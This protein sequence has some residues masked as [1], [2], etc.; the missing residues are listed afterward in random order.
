VDGAFGAWVKLSDTHCG[1]ADGLERAD[2][3]A[4]DLHKWMNMPYA[5]GC[6]L[7]KDKVSH[8]STFVYGHD[9]EYLKSGM[10][11]LGDAITNPLNLSLALSRAAYSFKAYMLFRAYGRKKFGQMVQKNIDHINYLAELIRKEPDLE[12]MAPV[13][14]NIACFRYKV[15]GLSESELEKFNRQIL[16]EF[17]EINP[18]MISDTTVKGKYMLR[19]CNVNHRTQGQDFDWLIEKVKESGEKIQSE[20]K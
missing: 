8:F 10:A 2:S 1:L 9:A 5:I 6:T 14:S 4:V 13:A 20:F 18:W 15:N 19:V 17:W 7:V 11:E 12:L 3:L 16:G